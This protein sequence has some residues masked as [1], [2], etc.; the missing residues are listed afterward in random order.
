MLVGASSSGSS[1]LAAFTVIDF[2]ALI[3]V[4][5]TDVAVMV[6]VPS[7]TPVILPL[8]SI[9]AIA[10]LL[11]E[12]VTS[13]LAPLGSTAAIKVIVFPTSTSVATC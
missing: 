2:S 5:S 7:A 12:N 4:F 1:I 3:A 10:V 11:V 8:A 9:V 13:L 6:T